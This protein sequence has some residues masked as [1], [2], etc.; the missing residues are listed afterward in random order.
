MGLTDQQKWAIAAD[1][2]VMRSIGFRHVRLLTQT[3]ALNPDVATWPATM[4]LTFPQP[5]P[6]ELARFNEFFQLVAEAG[7][8]SE[9]VFVMAGH[10]N[11]FYQDGATSEMYRQF[12][13]TTWGAMWSPTLSRIYF[14]GDLRLGDA[15]PDQVTVANHRDWLLREW[16]YFVAKCPACSIGIELMSGY[17]KMYDL[18]V[19]SIAWARASMTAQPKMFGCQMYPTSHGWLR[20][21]GWERSGTVNWRAM[22]LDWLGNLQR[23]AGPIPILA[24]EVG[25]M[26]QSDLPPPLT[27]DFTIQDQSDF[28]RA[29]FD[30][31][32]A[33]NVAANLWEF[34]DHDGI[35]RYGMLDARRNVR[36]VASALGPVLARASLSGIR[37]GVAYT[38]PE[39]PG[40]QWLFG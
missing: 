20:A 5:T 30:A 32:R 23:A 29:A 10:G 6:E 31:L 28:L 24:D 9:V 2:G 38:P 12:I 21:E 11:L 39:Y 15:D 22:V 25:V 35:G 18:A 33:A 13:D 26:L 40:L 19:G 36:P 1:L 4:F 14:G 16:P 3:K 7:M 37:S 34:A 27:S 8:T 17:A